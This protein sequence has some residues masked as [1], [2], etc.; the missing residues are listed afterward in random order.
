MADVSHCDAS[1]HCS[2]LVTDR[3]LIASRGCAYSGV[4]FRLVPTAGLSDGAGS[5]GRP[6]YSARRCLWATL[7]HDEQLHPSVD[8][9]S[10]NSFAL[11]PIH[12]SS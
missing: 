7:K 11:P 3:K 8:T 6:A 5:A 10:A 4:G 2:V 1:A 9:S 12:S